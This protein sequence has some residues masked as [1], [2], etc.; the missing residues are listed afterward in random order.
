[1]VPPRVAYVPQVPRLFSETLRENV[2]MGQ[3]WDGPRLVEALR[4][5]VLERDVATLERGADTLVG[6]RGVKLSG[7]QLQ[8][9]A[10]ARA[11]IAEPELL[12]VDD[13]SSALDVETERSLWLRLAG[14][15]VLA[16][17]NRPAAWRAADQIVVLDA[18]RIEAS[19]PLEA[20]V[21]ESRTMAALWSAA[22]ERLDPPARRA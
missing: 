3:P 11:L 22:G 16:V 6:P 13:L 15:T 18:G 4:L 5:A 12:V 14:R 21:R 19:G 1:M 9:T 10:A 7:G 8:R 17:S 20:L 2:L